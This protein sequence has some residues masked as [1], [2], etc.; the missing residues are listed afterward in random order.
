MLLES[1]ATERQVERGVE[2]TLTVG[3]SRIALDK[4]N[5]LAQIRM[6]RRYCRKPACIIGAIRL[7]RQ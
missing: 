6:N 5:Y 7:T 4:S 2:V 1:C 3:S